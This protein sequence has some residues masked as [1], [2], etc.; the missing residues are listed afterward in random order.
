MII[1][2]RG[3]SGS[4]KS[5]V[6]R[7]VMES[8]GEWENGILSGNEIASTTKGCPLYSTHKGI[9]VI[10]HYKTV[11]GGGD[12]IKKPDGRSGAVP[13]LYN[14]I[15]SL[16]FSYLICESIILS[17]DTKWTLE[18]AKTNQIRII[19]L[20]TPVEECISRIKGRRE[21]VGNEKPL[22]EKNTRN[23][24]ATIERARVKLTDQPNVEC[25]WASSE[26]APRLILSW[27]GYGNAKIKP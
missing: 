26:Q 8:L 16:Q 17:E 3:T 18:L 5:T 12:R 13:T 1:Q 23:R 10:G 22:N 15:C 7:K 24:V 19:F 6:V 25:R 27:L 4:G 11:C 2:V 14:L 9:V 20:T 21:K